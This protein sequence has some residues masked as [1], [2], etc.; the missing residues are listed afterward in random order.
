M[1]GRNVNWDKRNRPKNPVNDQ[2]SIAAECSDRAKFAQM[3]VAGV[4][5]KPIEPTTLV[6]EVAEILG[7][8]A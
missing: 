4:I 5:S 8:D 3:G 1:T 7:W 2:A 6:A